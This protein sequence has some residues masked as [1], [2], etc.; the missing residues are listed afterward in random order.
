MI[1]FN[2]TFYFSQIRVTFYPAGNEIAWN[3][4]I[5]KFFFKYFHIIEYVKYYISKI[6][7]LKS[8]AFLY[9]LI[10]THETWNIWM[11]DI[12]SSIIL[13]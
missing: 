8:S 4:H 5:A 10:V 1:S 13:N 3:H 9:I 11:E 2:K 12:R 7:K 6:Q